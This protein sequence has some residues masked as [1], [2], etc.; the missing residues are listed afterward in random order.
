MIDRE[1]AKTAMEET[2]LLFHNMPEFNSVQVIWYE[3]DRAV[4]L[5]LNYKSDY[6]FPNKV[7]EVPVVKQ[8]I[9]EPDSYI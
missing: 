7:L 1:R 4:K 2:I 8:I 6:P 3:G 9:G 5:F